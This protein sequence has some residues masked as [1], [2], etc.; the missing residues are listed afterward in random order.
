MGPA[1]LEVLVDGVCS[2]GVAVAVLLA[3]ALAQLVEAVSY[4]ST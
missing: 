3:A 4:T 1:S 2:G